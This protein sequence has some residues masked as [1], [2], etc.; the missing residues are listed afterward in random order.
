[1]NKRNVLIL[2]QGLF[3]LLFCFYN[4]AEIQEIKSHA[5]EITRESTQEIAS[6]LKE[7]KQENTPEQ[8]TF[9]FTKTLKPTKSPT[10]LATIRADLKCPEYANTVLPNN[11]DH[12]M[13]LLEHGNKTGQPREYT[14][15]VFR[16]FNNLI[17]SSEYVNAATF[18][19]MLNKLPSLLHTHCTPHQLQLVLPDINLFESDS[20]SNNDYFKR[21]IETTLYNRFKVSFDQ[22]KSQPERFITQISEHLC[23]IAQEQSGIEQLRSMVMRFLES[24]VSKLIWRPQDGQLTWE[25]FKT[26]SAQLGMLADQNV[27][28]DSNDLD[29]IYWTLIHRYAFFI[30]IAGS[31][32]PLH[33][34]DTVKR[35]ISSGQLV[36]LKTEQAHSENNGSLL[37]SRET[38]LK[39]MILT[40]ETRRRSCLRE[41]LESNLESN[42]ETNEPGRTGLVS[43]DAYPTNYSD[44][45]SQ[46]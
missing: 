12:L 9:G 18:S 13:Q 32:L 22:F 44:L 15:S 27:I 19:D 25:S 20:D 17:K 34:F 4:Y 36:L 31:D 7:S 5:Q 43:Y 1:M 37:E 46:A 23:I 16:L 45:S 3:S 11:F 26:I 40:G 42:L 6:R 2:A 38:A 29:D 33:F 24:Y 41:N 10:S 14:H 28:Q 30:D 8:K 39:R 35:D 21:A